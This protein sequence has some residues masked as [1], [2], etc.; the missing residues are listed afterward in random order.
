MDDGFRPLPP[1]F[2]VSMPPTLESE[3]PAPRRRWPW[4]L[5]AVLGLGLALLQTA[6]W[7][8]DEAALDPRWRPYYARAC[9]WVGCSLPELRDPAAIRSRRLSVRPHPQHAD[10]LLLEAMIEN[11][12]A[13][14]QPY[15]A[16]ELQFADIQGRPLAARRFRPDEYLG[17]EVEVGSLMPVG[18]PVRIAVAMQSP[19]EQAVN[20][21]IAFW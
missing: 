4:A 17:G 13:F 2:A 20:Y 11:Q 5:L 9:G 21:Q 19:G 1:A 16:I 6:I 12:A 3:V 7:A 10:A 14:P 8:F 18:Q 15:P